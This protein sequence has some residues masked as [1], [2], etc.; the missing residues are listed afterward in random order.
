[1][2]EENQLIC[3]AHY[4]ANAGNVEWV[5]HYANV[6]ARKYLEPGVAGDPF[7]VWTELNIA[8]LGLRRFVKSENRIISME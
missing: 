3:P 1:M 7:L 8:I 5:Q 4:L 2:V 6:D